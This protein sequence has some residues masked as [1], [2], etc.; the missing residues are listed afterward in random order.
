MTLSISRLKSEIAWHLHP[1]ILCADRLSSNNHT[2][3]HCEKTVILFH[4][5]VFKETRL[6]CGR[7]YFIYF[8]GEVQF[9]KDSCKYE[10]RLCTWPW[11]SKVTIAALNQGSKEKCLIVSLKSLDGTAGAPQN[12]RGKWPRWWKMMNRFI[13][14][15]MQMK[16]WSGFHLDP[17]W[18]TSFFLVTECVD[19][20]LQ[21]QRTTS[22]NKKEQ[23][24]LLLFGKIK[25]NLMHF[26]FRVLLLV[27]YGKEV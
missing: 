15:E 10:I 3:C 2:L 5:H 24:L 14:E 13:L 27:D 4:L 18:W 22:K 6:Y 8:P 11:R 20:F 7:N 19:T 26:S 17:E 21:N 12:L 25:K 9:L 1:S 16:Y 23:R